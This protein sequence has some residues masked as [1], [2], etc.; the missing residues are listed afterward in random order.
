MKFQKI[1]WTASEGVNNK[2][3]IRFRKGKEKNTCNVA[4]T[5]AYEVPQ[6]LEPVGE[7]LKPAVEKILQGGQ[8]L[9]P[10]HQ[11]ACRLRL[12]YCR[13]RFN[14]AFRKAM[15]ASFNLLLVYILGLN[16]V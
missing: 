13:L 10:P 14:P 5:I 1:H 16:V 9:Y 6:V 3:A 12:E 2:G 15:C 4:L 7:A 8:L 11:R